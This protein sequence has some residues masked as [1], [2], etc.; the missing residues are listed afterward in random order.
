VFTSDDELI[1]RLDILLQTSGKIFEI[2]S[3]AVSKDNLIRR[4]SIEEFGSFCWTLDEG[5]SS[6]LDRD[7]VT[8][9]ELDVLI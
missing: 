7:G 3:R 1:A 4:L 8:C 5:M 2:Q 6:G 9:A